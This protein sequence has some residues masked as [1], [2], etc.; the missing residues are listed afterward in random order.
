LT[1]DKNNPLLKKMQIVAR[2]AVCIFFLH[3]RMEASVAEPI[4]TLVTPLAGEDIAQPCAYNLAVPEQQKVEAVFVIF[5]RG[6]DSH[7]FF[8]DPDVRSFAHHHRL[9]MMMPLHCVSKDQ[10]DIDVDPAKG[11]GRALFQALK[12]FSDSTGHHELAAVPLIY[13]GFS[14]AGALAARMPG[15]A[16]ERSIAA[17]LS[18]A[19]QTRPLGLNTIVHS[20]ESASVPQLVLVGGKDTNVG[21]QSGYRYFNRY[22]AAGAP[23]L[24]ATQNNGRHCCTIDAKELILSWLES[25]LQRRLGENARLAPLKRTGGLYAFFR[26]DRTDVL[27]GKSPTYNAVDLSV[28]LTEQMAKPDRVSAG[29]LPSKQTA[30]E[31]MI[32]ADRPSRIV[33][34][35]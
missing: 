26:M 1:L 7:R 29:W 9:A 24:F 14:G 20:K 21:T 2:C 34:P 5:E 19:D 25:I 4:Q 10:T 27:A 18:H 30:R 22:L 35:Q 16:P 23:W 13:L 28:K 11:L 31:W 33:M 32:Y 12:Q 6:K 15:Y 3:L 17:I 8:E